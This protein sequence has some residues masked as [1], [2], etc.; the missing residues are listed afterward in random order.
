MKTNF[1]D[2]AK[3]GGRAGRND[4]QWGWYDYVRPTFTGRTVLDV[5]TG[6]S[7]IKERFPE[8]Q[9]TTHEASEQ[10]PADIHGDLG[11]V[12]SSSFDAV[13]CF[14]VIEHVV[15]YGMLAWNMARIARKWVFLTTP[16]RDV[17]LNTSPFHFYEFH[18]WE[19]LNLFEATGMRLAQAWVQQWEGPAKFD[20]STPANLLTGVIMAGRADL[21]AKPFLHPVALLMEK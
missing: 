5:G 9:I 4:C 11:A 16:G 14:D 21:L 17:T 20:G 10:C 2:L 18:P 6:L 1:T 19:I 13:T 8:A 3:Q 15:D 12:A 7:K